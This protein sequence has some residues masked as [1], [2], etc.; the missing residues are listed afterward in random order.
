MIKRQSESE[1]M[2]NLCL[3]LE[4][5]LRAKSIA[6]ASAEKI[7]LSIGRA[8]LR[9]FLFKTAVHAVLLL[10]W[11]PSVMTYRWSGGYWRIL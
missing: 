7:A 9:I 11:E 10:S 6:W 5:M 8:F 1:N 2:I 4:V 3:L